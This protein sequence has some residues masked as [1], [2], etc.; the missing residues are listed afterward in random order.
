[1]FREPLVATTFDDHEHGSN[2]VSSLVAHSLMLVKHKLGA[3]PEKFFLHADNTFK[4]T[5]NTIT[6]L[7]LH[8]CSHNSKVRRC[9]NFA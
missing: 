8:G 1:M 5:K 9:G 6:I 4:E 7:F 2:M 3:L